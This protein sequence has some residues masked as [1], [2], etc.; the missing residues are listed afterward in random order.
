MS[1]QGRTLCSSFQRWKLLQ[2]SEVTDEAKQR[3]F[4]DRWSRGTKLWERDCGV[5]DTGL[6]QPFRDLHVFTC[7]HW[8][9]DRAQCSSQ[10]CKICNQIF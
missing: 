7:H 3:S 8:S 1:S 4:P 10:K 9:C 5:F 2:V 6:I